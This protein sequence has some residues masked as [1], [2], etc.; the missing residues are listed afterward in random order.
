MRTSKKVNL[1]R[2]I[3]SRRFSVLLAVLFL[4]A[5]LL[6]ANPKMKADNGQ[7]ADNAGDADFYY[8]LEEKTDEFFIAFN[9]KQFDRLLAMLSGEMKGQFTG[10]VAAYKKDPA[11]AGKEIPDRW[12]ILGTGNDPQKGYFSYVDFR[13][14]GGFEKFTFHWLK[15]P[16]GW[17]IDRMQHVNLAAINKD[18]KVE[19]VPPPI[20]S[21]HLSAA[22]EAKIQA[23]A[24]D[25]IKA[26]QESRFDAIL[27]LIPKGMRED[28][29]GQ[30]TDGEQLRKGYLGTQ[31]HVEAIRPGEWDSEEGQKAHLELYV[32]HKDGIG[33]FISNW[34]LRKID[35]Q[36]QVARML[37][38][39]KL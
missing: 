10:F 30:T 19:D 25:L 14:G 13:V 17:T 26:L 8:A 34:E 7:S 20:V 36:W 31:I 16:T 27:K 23:T 29:Q 37:Q 32:E 2:K 35:G 3:A 12:R 18:G 21:L 38:S 6:I 1:L 5:W 9:S 11:A 24:G 28:F 22:E 15:S 4:P 33:D 39:S